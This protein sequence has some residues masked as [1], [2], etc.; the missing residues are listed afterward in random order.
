MAGSYTITFKDSGSGSDSSTKRTTIEDIISDGASYVSAVTADNVYN[1]RTGRGIKLG[2]SSKT[3]TLTLTL[4][5]EVKATSIVVSVRKYSD[6]EKTF[7]IQG[8]DYTAD[9]GDDFTNATYTYETATAI[10]SIVLGSTPKRIYFTSVT[11]NCEG[12]DVP[13][14]VANFCQTEIGHFAA[15]NADPNSF[16]L[17]SIGSKGG[18]TIVRIDQDAAKNTQM[19]DYLQVTGLA[20][21]GEDVAE[22]GAAAM[23]VE[24]DTPTPV[25]DSLTLEI[26]WSTVNWAG[27]WMVQNLRVAVAD[28]QYATIPLTPITCAEVY[29]KAKDDKVALNDVTVTYAN[30]KNVYVKDESGA[31]L[32]YLPAN[33]TWKAGDKLA[34]VEGVL[35]IYNGLYEVK[36]SADQVAAVVATAG[37][38]PAPVELAVA[39]V[40]ADVN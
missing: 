26:L 37:E 30:G 23:A 27:R 13:V 20:S 33:T 24:F 8:K 39:P 4:A 9:D 31:M 32:L 40:A 1:A 28:C 16:V 18:K 35:D 38:A 15:E 22:G 10:S 34:G 36:P 19:F 11:V 2:T 25:N 17:L 7:T 12:E 5:D 14:T 21:T 29:S 3:G 6:S